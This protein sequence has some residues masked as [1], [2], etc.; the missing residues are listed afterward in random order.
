MQPLALTLGEPAGIRADVA[1]A[2][3]LPAGPSSHE[4]AKNS[5]FESLTA[6]PNPRRSLVQRVQSPASHLFE[7]GINLCATTIRLHGVVG[8]DNIS[9][10]EYQHISTPAIM[11]DK[12][13]TGE[14]IPALK[15]VY[16]TR[17]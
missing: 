3:L 9:S 15:G 8:V 11:V 1:Q 14:P 5:A 6:R 16:P 12:A 10:I 7:D 4:I 2:K 17:L 13:D